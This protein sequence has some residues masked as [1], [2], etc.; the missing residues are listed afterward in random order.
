MRSRGWTQPILLEKL[1]PLLELFQML[2]SLHTSPVQLN[3]DYIGKQLQ[4]GGKYG[5]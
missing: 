1:Y 4:T 2:I 3:K 5:H